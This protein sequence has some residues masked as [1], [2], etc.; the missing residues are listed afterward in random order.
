MNKYFETAFDSFDKLEVAYSKKE[1]LYNY[2][3]S[4]KQRDF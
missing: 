4:L 3:H 2:A 1:V